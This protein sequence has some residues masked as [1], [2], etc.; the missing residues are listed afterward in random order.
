MPSLLS[1]T[2][3]RKRLIILLS[4]SG[5]SALAYLP[6][7]Q[8]GLNDQQL[9]TETKAY[10]V[11]G[12]IIILGFIALISLPIADKVKIPMPFLRK[13]D[14]GV[15]EQGIEHSDVL[16]TL[17]LCVVPLFIIIPAGMLLQV[18]DNPG[19]VLERFLTTPFAAINLQIVT[20][21]FLTSLLFLTQKP[22]LTVVLSGSVLAFIHSLT[23]SD[24]TA[25]DIIFQTLSNGFMGSIFAWVYIKRGFELA[26]LGHA[27]SHLLIV[28]IM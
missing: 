5:F 26:I 7:L 22:V 21:L 25:P 27:V 14:T 20:L 8:A 11:I 3:I 12:N 1:F 24:F 9:A 2:S 6:F 10:F 23:A 28:M 18:P 16:Q 17:S 13:L 4:L 19:S 15:V